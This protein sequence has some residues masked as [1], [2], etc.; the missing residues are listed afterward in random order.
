M[1]RK[2]KKSKDEFYINPEEF[3]AAIIEF[4]DTGEFSEELGQMVCTLAQRIGNNTCFINYTYRDEMIQETIL[5][6]SRVL[7]RKKYDPYKGN[8]FSYFSMVGINTFKNYLKQ[9]DKKETMMEQYQ[10]QMYEELI[11]SDIIDVNTE[12]GE[13]NEW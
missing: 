4:Y 13:T 1:S 8:A 10:S 9:A 5:K 2:T 3:K 6:I 11:N 7:K 12:D